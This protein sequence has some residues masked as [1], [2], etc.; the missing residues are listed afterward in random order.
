MLF[1]W[2]RTGDE[3]YHLW[4]V[5]VDGTGLKQ[6]TDGAWHDYNACW[7]PDG[8]I[9][10][11]CTRFVQFAYCWNAPVG[12]VHRIDADGSNLRKLSSNYLND[13]TPYVL[14]DG[15][16][17]YSRWE[18]VDKPACPI[19]SLWTLNPDGT[20]LR[21]Y[22]GNRVLSPG[23]FM[24]PRSIPG[25]TKIL[26]TMTGHNGPARGAVGVI[27]RSKGLNAQQSIENITPE[28]AVPGVR[29]GTGN[30]SGSKQYSCPVP[31][32]GRRLLVSC[33]GPVLVR[34]LAG[35]CQAV[36]LPAPEDGMQYFCTQ[37]VRPRKRPPVVP[38]ALPQDAEPFATV[39][40]QNVYNG[41]EPKVARGEVTHI[42]VVR[43]V[44]KT[45]RLPPQHGPFG[46][47]FPCISCGATYAAK[48][49]LG[50]VPVEPD[51]SVCFRVPSG[52]PVYFMALDAQGRAVQRMR[53]F[54][55]FMPGEVQGCIGCHEHRRQASRAELATACNR[56]PRA[57]APPEWGRGGF[58]YSRIVQP[59]LD[60]HCVE[61]HGGL[62]PPKRVDL[63]GAKTDY[64]SASYD[65]LAREN[66]GNRGSPLISWI[67]T[68]NGQEWNIF[69]I[70]PKTWG[71]PA[72]K[73]AELVLSGH[74]D[75]EGKPQINLA[76]PERRR[77]LAWIDLNVPYYGSTETAYP[78]AQSCRKV[79][80]VRLDAVLAEV[81][82]RRCA[83]CHAEGKLPRRVWTRIT[84]PEL[85][86]FL[87][88]PLAR[89]AG[90][91][92]RCGRA[93]FADR[94]DPDYQA[95]LATF[96]PVRKMLAERPRMDMPGARP[97]PTLCRECQ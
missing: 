26:C 95:I 93:V 27:D 75:S 92:Q 49:V 82:K 38:S 12:I 85:N 89:K 71:S 56:T 41:L 94:S 39:Y 19:Q 16:I 54:T 42:R 72:S 2:R 3:G 80:P 78:E 30:F 74:P 25:T 52:V 96:E 91:S 45:V 63:T 69:E 33:Q 84:Q 43:E 87:T 10:F 28:V 79:Y 57:L 11:L 5:G 58:D 90:G 15:R 48:E 8:G 13:F 21:Q 36:A 62:D 51:G 97:S 7:L 81:A 60:R 68:Y 86:S 34:T 35:D 20:G 59:V 1:S 50:E 83:S 40:L 46:W 55:H 31:L 61:C 76:E 66:K 44:E 9:A 23:T 65:V 14:S 17:C 67:P 32:D 73:L 88:A 47:Q 64:F 77:I 18:Y 29:Q 53:S 22:F 6:L 24:E 70:A 37:P 4:T